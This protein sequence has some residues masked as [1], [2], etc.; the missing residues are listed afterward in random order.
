ML[1]DNVSPLTKYST[2]DPRNR[3]GMKTEMKT[4]R[5]KKASKWALR[6]HRRPL[7]GSRGNALGEGQ[8]VKPPELGGNLQLKE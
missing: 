6:G 4:G 5:N 8:R 1:T 2:C 7:K 3:M